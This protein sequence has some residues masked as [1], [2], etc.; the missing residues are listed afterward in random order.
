[1]TNQISTEESS[2]GPCGHF[3]DFRVT[4]KV[5]S[6]IEGGVVPNRLDLTKF[7]N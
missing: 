7:T 6:L 3:L 4:S 2:E 5:F 1:M